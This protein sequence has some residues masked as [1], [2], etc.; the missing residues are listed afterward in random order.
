MKTITRVIR[1]VPLHWV[2]D[3]FPLRS[4]FSYGGGNLFNPFLLLDVDPI[5]IVRG[6]RRDQ[7][8]LLGHYV[9]D[10]PHVP[11]SIMSVAFSQIVE[12]VAN[13]T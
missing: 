12:R 9:N 5:G 13:G 10:R 6:K 8:F 11:P 1:D 4:L 2:G 7:S 3:G